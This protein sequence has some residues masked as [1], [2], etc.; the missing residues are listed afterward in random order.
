MKTIQELLLKCRADNGWQSDYR[1]AKELKIP[2][3]RIYD[4][5]SGSRQPDTYALVKVAECLKLDPLELIAQFGEQTAKREEE[6][7]FWRS[8]RG[9]VGRRIGAYIVALCF[10]LFGMLG[11]NLGENRVAVFR[12]PKYA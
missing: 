2:T 9:R 8:F 12:R 5:M 6:K 10:T 11:G 7:E 1:L 3:Q 4:Y